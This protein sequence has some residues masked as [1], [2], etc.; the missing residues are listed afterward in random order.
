MFVI[1]ETVTTLVEREEG[2]DEMLCKHPYIKTPVGAKRVDLVNKENRLQ[3]TPFGCGRCLP[4]RANRARVWTHRLLLEQTQHEESVFATLTYNNENL[5]GDGNLEKEELQKFWKRLRK[6]LDR[7]IRYF[8]VGEYGDKSWR[9]HYHAAIFG[10][11]IYDREALQETWDKGFIHLGELNKN[12]IRY[13]LE[14]ILKNLYWQNPRLDGRTP[15]FSVQSRKPG[16]GAIAINEVGKKISGNSFYKGNRIRE[17]Q[18]GKSKLPLGRFLQEK[19]DK[20]VGIRHEAIEA[21]LMDYQEEM[22]KCLNGERNFF[23]SLVSEGGPRRLSMEKRSKI[24]K[25][26][27]KL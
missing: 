19:L 10:V 24:F 8:A 15:E 22:F 4:C 6:R 5:P 18:Y 7:K 21:D 20:A 23:D 1:L 17:L 3:S 16:I 11:G 13:M 26:G 27:K 12:S 9:P 2:C 14:Y 25:K